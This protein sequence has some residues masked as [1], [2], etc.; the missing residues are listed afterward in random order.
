MVCRR[1]HIQEGNC[2][3]EQ[4]WLRQLPTEEELVPALAR[5]RISSYDNVA[6]EGMEEATGDHELG[7]E[8]AKEEDP[9][10]ELAH[11]PDAETEPGANAGPLL[12]ENNELLPSAMEGAAESNVEAEISWQAASSHALPILTGGLIQQWEQREFSTDLLYA[13]NLP[14]GAPSCLMSS[15]QDWEQARG[16]PVCY[17]YWSNPRPS[18]YRK[19]LSSSSSQL[20][21]NTDGKVTAPKAPAQTI[22]RQVQ[23]MS[24]HMVEWTWFS[25][26]SCYQKRQ[27]VRNAYQQLGP[28]THSTWAMQ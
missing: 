9:L 10:V 8:S 14:K 15:A 17:T 13:L 27:H 7:E 18:A 4:H 22:L 23:R 25:S 21:P 6:H 3:W 16:Q 24:L 19:R 20:K 2:S 28:E 5:T 26:Y 1:D 12:A 11:E